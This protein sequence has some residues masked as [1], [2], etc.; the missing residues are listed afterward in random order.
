MHLGSWK[1][2]EVFLSVLS[3]METK[4]PSKNFFEI[5]KVIIV[6]TLF[7]IRNMSQVYP[8]KSV[9]NKGNLLYVIKH[10]HKAE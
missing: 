8:H 5:S 7:L 4:P 1:S 9:E 2:V 3:G 6:L 10:N